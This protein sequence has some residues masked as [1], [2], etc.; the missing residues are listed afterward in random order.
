MEL[1]WLNHNQEKA[2]TD[3]QNISRS[4]PASKIAV[5]GVKT[6]CTPGLP[7]LTA[8]LFK[9]EG[10]WDTP[11]DKFLMQQVR[12]APKVD[13]CSHSV[14]VDLIPLYVGCTIKCR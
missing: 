11:L 3:V 4:G 12:S 7:E 1:H 14:H 13:P 5:A 2:G 8:R 6:C 10:E 9:M